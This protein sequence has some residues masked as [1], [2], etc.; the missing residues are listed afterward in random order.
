MVTAEE[1]RLAGSSVEL[2]ARR[3][4]QG[5]TPV[6]ALHGWLDNAGT[7]DRLAPHLEGTDLVALDFPGHGKSG[8]RPPGS[9]AHFVDWVAEVFAAAR[10]L[11]W[12]RFILMGHSMGAGVASLAAGTFPDLFQGLIL[13]EGLGPFTTPEEEAPTLLARALAYTPSPSSRIYPTIEQ[14]TQR[15]V[16]RGLTQAAAE[17]LAS[18]ALQESEGG[19]KF[20]YD[21]QARAP[22]RA[23]LSEGQ[24]RAFLRAI[25][26]PTLTITASDGL[27]MPPSFEGREAEVTDLRTFTCRGGHHL[28]L[29]YPERIV[30]AVQDFLSEVRGV[31]GS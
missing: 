21:P 11:R 23:R 13:I 10:A 1:I 26:A 28:H 29:D 22:S 19:W 7:Y 2:A 24:V 9:A 25:T 31:P 14:A 27:Q 16:Q 20:H 18:R 5:P 12:D 6:L 3:W 17:C 30:R 8:H 4:R 15:L